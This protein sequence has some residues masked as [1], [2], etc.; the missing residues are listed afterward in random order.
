MQLR[1][2]TGEEVKEVK[3]KGISLAGKATGRNTLLLCLLYF[4]Y[5]LYFHCFLS[6][7]AEPGSENPHA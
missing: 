3:E 7:G 4:L 2:R 1:P 5:F 6:C